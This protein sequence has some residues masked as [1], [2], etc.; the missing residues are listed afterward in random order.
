MKKILIVLIC[1]VVSVTLISA[2]EVSEKKEIA[3]F[4]LSHVDWSV[5]SGALSLVD[6]QVTGTFTDIGRFDVR[7]LDL[8]L[9]ADDVS[10]FIELIRDVKEANMQIDEKYRLGEETFTE[11]DFERLTG[12]FLIVIPSLTFYDSYVEDTDDGPEWEVSLQT[13]FSIIKVQDSS[14]L[15]QFSID[16]YG[17]GKTQKEATQ[18]AASAISSQLDY[19]LRTIEEFKLK[20][21]IIE[22]MPGGRVILELGSDMGLQKGDEFSI[23]N[24]RLLDSGHTVSDITGLLVISDVKNDLSYGQVVY[25]DQNVLPGD[26]LAEIPRAG[27]DVSLYLRGFLDTEDTSA[28]ISG[29]S[30][31]LKSVLCQGFF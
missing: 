24:S 15:A 16:T 17:S 18:N 28:P 29:G 31:G 20:T 6:Q 8:R 27:A 7:G 25:N 11:A 4:S 22:V 13:S 19:E 21:G 1:A 23:V 26:Q 12:S 30:I 10:G 2:Q 9:E 5:P 14:T 3:V